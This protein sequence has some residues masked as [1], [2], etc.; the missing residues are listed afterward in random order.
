MWLDPDAP[1][2][3]EEEL[4]DAPDIPSSLA[5]SGADSDADEFVSVEIGKL[6]SAKSSKEVSVVSEAS[7]IDKL[8]FELSTS[9]SS[10]KKLAEID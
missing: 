8:L 3:E 1:V 4:L 9:L 6:D 5:D 7:D 2:E 10:S